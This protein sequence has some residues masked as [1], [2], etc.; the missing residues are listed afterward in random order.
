[1][2]HH[3]QTRTS[4]PSVCSLSLARRFALEAASWSCYVITLVNPG[5]R[6]RCAFCTAGDRPIALAS[7]G[8]TKPSTSCARA[9]GACTAPSSLAWRVQRACFTGHRRASRFFVSVLARTR[10]SKGSHSDQSIRG[11]PRVCMLG[12]V[13]GRPHQHP[14]DPTL[15]YPPDNP[16]RHPTYYPPRSHSNRVSCR[17]VN[18]QPCPRSARAPCHSSYHFLYIYRDAAHP[19]AAGLR[20]LRALR[21]AGVTIAAA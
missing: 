20:A 16:T 11:A 5:R 10:V 17:F 3:E 4:L 19:V 9:S 15:P 18:S 13:G 2:L 6:V 1:M 21:G 14:G 7:E 8:T 12:C